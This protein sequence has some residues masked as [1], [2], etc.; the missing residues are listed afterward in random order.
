MTGPPDT[1]QWL[2]DCAHSIVWARSCFGSENRIT[3]ELAHVGEC[4]H[5]GEI[6][7]VMEDLGLRGKTI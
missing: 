5:I 6:W 2:L 1:L 4:D 7:R 3:V